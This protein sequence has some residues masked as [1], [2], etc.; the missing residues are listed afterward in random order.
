MALLI[1]P[2]KERNHFDVLTGDQELE[3]RTATYGPEVDQ[4][5]HAKSVS[6]IVRDDNI[7]SR[8]GAHCRVCYNYL[9]SDR[10]EGNIAFIIT[11][12]L[13]TF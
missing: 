7:N 9:I 4:S 1:I 3:V 8:E 6:H 10:C 13:Y 2:G 5:K 12:T 11:R